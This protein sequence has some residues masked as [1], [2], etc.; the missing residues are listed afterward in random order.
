M[1]VQ[2]DLAEAPV[3]ELL[4]FEITVIGPQK[5][6]PPG[7]RERDQA[8]LRA[9]KRVQREADK[10]QGRVTVRV[11]DVDRFHAPT[12]TSGRDL[13]GDVLIAWGEPGVPYQMEVRRANRAATGPILQV[14]RLIARKAK[15]PNF[16]LHNR[17]TKRERL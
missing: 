9:I 7:M 14:A 1:L 2:L 11:V 5:D 17:D 13:P 4:R 8:L 12:H 15:L 10:T 16:D 3:H 6:S